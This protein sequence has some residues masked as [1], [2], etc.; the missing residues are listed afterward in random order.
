MIKYADRGLVERG[1][2][3]PLFGKLYLVVCVT[4]FS[5]FSLFASYYYLNRDPNK[6]SNFHLMCM[7]ESVLDSDFEAM[8]SIILFLS[9]TV[10]FYIILFVMFWAI[11]YFLR[12]RGFSKRIPQIIGKFKRNVLSL[13]ETFVYAFLFYS[14]MH[15]NSFLLK[16]HKHFGI[17]IDSIRMYG[18]TH[19]LL[20]NNLLEGIIW[21]LYIMYNL[22][23]HIPDKKPE[24]KFYISGLQN[25]E[26]RRMNNVSDFSD[27]RFAKPKSK[28][29][30]VNQSVNKNS[31][32]EMPMID[33]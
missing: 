7:K 5:V 31:F 13:K 19:S 1:A 4:F 16:Y 26:P 30:F 29:K 27:V 18:F 33:V 23:E 22:S 24:T 6:K 28:F 10:P 15:L 21:P 20:I 12:S 9:L 14:D 11:L 25:L 32:S 3:S 17:S 8:K 2:V